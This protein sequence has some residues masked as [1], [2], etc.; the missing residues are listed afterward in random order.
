MAKNATFWCHTSTSDGEKL[1]NSCSAERT[2]VE[3]ESIG[4]GAWAPPVV[5][6]CT[7]QSTNRLLRSDLVLFGLRVPGLS[8]PCFGVGLAPA[9]GPST[10]ML[11]TRRV[12]PLLLGSSVGPLQWNRIPTTMKTQELTVTQKDNSYQEI[13]S[14]MQIE[15]VSQNDKCSLSFEQALLVLCE[16]T[17]E[18]DYAKHVRLNFKVLPS[19]VLNCQTPTY[20]ETHTCALQGWV[21]ATPP[22]PRVSPLAEEQGCRLASQTW[23][24]QEFP[25][26]LSPARTPPWVPA[27]PGHRQRWI[28]SYQQWITDVLGKTKVI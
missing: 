10:S 4:R 3:S 17:H 24:S 28:K 25:W 22:G 15:E 2:S 7:Y 16:R 26:C 5:Y 14:D 1:L 12:L 21:G 19:Q 27:W 11:Q 23:S 9:S 8:N 6:L 20:R 13:I 18:T